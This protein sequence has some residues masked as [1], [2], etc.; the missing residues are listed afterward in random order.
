MT[1]L[2]AWARNAGLIALFAAA[3]A[4]PALALQD[5][6]PD[7]GPR[8]V[9]ELTEA[10]VAAS[11]KKLEMAYGALVAMWK[12]RF[13][14]LGT[15]FDAPAILAYRGNIRTSCG[16]MSPSNAAYCP[17]RNA[18]YFDEVFV[19]EQGRMAA[20]ALGTDG[21]MA[22]VGIIAHEMGHAVAAQL[23]L[24]SR[25]P[26]EN[27]ATADCLAGAFANQSEK[28]KSLEAGDLDEAFF[29]MASAGDPA[30][31]TTGDGRVDR[32]IA[33]RAAYLGHGTREQR[34]SNFKLGLNGGAGACL[35]V[36]RSS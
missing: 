32:M 3:S 7:D 9:V 20:Q 21:D 15:R 19:A 2:N 16:I 10:D 12:D 33:R 28:D 17:T 25:I 35:P 30:P 18:I 13:D 6:A 5:R 34:L 26:Y 24:D 23:G 1:S 14:K 27:E 29:G 22:A 4:S 11:N 31:P 8:A 36:F